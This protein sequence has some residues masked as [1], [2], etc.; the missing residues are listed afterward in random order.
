[1]SHLLEK[2]DEWKPLSLIIKHCLPLAPENSKFVISNYE[3]YELEQAAQDALRV[4][5]QREKDTA[6]E[7]KALNFQG[8]KMN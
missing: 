2:H 1:M 7:R 8:K 6:K 3:K 5:I 4:I